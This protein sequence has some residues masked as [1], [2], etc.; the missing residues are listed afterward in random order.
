M[1]ELHLKQEKKEDRPHHQEHNHEN[2][3][4][5]LK[6]CGCKKQKLFGHVM[7]ICTRKKGVEENVNTTKRF[8]VEKMEEKMVVSCPEKRWMKKMVM[9]FLMW[10]A[11]GHNGCRPSSVQ[12]TPQ[13]IGFCLENLMVCGRNV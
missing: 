10:V 12:Q 3:I 4:K 1:Y 2:K 8:I 7:N 13:Q 5:I 6:I 11:L 9:G